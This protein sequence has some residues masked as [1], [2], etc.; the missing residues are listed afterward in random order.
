MD[1]LPESDAQAVV[2]AL[3]SG[4]IC[5]FY[6]GGQGTEPE[7]LQLPAAAGSALAPWAILVMQNV[8]LE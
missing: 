8:K 5:K 6:A 7:V 4:S 3:V 1:M 2:M